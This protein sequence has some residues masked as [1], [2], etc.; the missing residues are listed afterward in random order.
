MRF[1]PYISLND[2]QRM[3]QLLVEILK[4]KPHS[5][6]HPGDLDWRAFVVSAGFA[7]EDMIRLW[8][9]A[10][11]NLLGWLFV[12][13]SAGMLD[14]VVHPDVSGTE[15]ERQMLAE[16]EHYLSSLSV[17][18][19]QTLAM[20]V[21]ADDARRRILLEARG[22]FGSDCRVHFAQSLLEK[23]LVPHLPDGFHFLKAQDADHAERRADLHVDAFSPGSTMTAEK[24]Q[25]VMNAPDYD[26][27]MDVVIVA[28]DGRYAAFALGWCD[29][30]SQIGLFE[31]VGTRKAFQRMG[32]GKAALYEAMRRMQE[33]GMEMATVRTTRS[34]PGVLP[35]YEAAGFQQMNTIWC[36][37]GFVLG[38][39]S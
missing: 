23:N 18:E 8:I 17:V 27:E 22:Y 19:P 30:E 5:T 29:P 32:L 7:L 1:Q 31:P 9:D 16:A 34:L 35:F 12:Y 4:S 28:P 25:T 37:Q 15:R 3:K 11:D 13:P 33:R 10:D 6:Y 20:F 26:P 36:Y 39:E 38:S 14:L 2:L 24:Y 21:F